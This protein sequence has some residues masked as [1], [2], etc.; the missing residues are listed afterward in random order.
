MTL[1]SYASVFFG[2]DARTGMPVYIRVPISELGSDWRSPHEQ[3]EGKRRTWS[4]YVSD[5]ARRLRMLCP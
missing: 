4:G 1:L 3:Q 2:R 5:L